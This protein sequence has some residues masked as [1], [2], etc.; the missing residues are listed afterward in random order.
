MSKKLIYGKEAREIAR[1]GT[2]IVADAVAPTLGAQGKA[3]LI[4]CDGLTPILADDGGTILKH[5]SFSNP[6]VELISKY[7]QK[8]GLKMH[9]KSGDGRSTAVTLMR[10]LT[11]AALDEIGNDGHKIPEV[12]ERLLNGLT[13]T[14]S[15][16]EE[17]RTDIKD[18]DLASVATIASLDPEA[19]RVIADAF[20]Q[21]G[22]NGI[23]TVEESPIVGISSEV[24]KGMRFQKGLITPYFINE[25]E[26]ERA[27]LETPHVF[28]TDRR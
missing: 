23:V 14:L 3:V 24:V 27:V 4:D 18:E 9:N 7:I 28:I 5:L 20:L 25:A 8:L 19:G 16:L 17:F 6:E 21:V 10:S 22:R 12:H 15:M 2:N 26:K 11:N 13:Q 1:R